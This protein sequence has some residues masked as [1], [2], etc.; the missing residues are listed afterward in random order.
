MKSFFVI[1]SVSSKWTY[2]L[3]PI[4]ERYIHNNLPDLH[5][6]VLEITQRN[7]KNHT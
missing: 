4:H 1:I 5:W 6:P 3:L 2:N 7:E